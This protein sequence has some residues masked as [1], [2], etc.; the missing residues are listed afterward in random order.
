MQVASSKLLTDRE[1]VQVGIEKL[2]RDYE[3][4]SLSEVWKDDYGADSDW[5]LKH[6]EEALMRAVIASYNRDNK[7]ILEVI[8]LADMIRDQF[9]NPAYLPSLHPS[10]PVAPTE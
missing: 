5:K 3:R 2:L 1:S 8:T 4:E 6:E 10:R 7:Y 9:Y